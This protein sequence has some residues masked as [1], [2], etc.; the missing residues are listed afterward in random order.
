VSPRLERHLKSRLGRARTGV[1][2][3]DVDS[4]EPLNE[5]VDGRAALVEVGGIESRHLGALPDLA[6]LVR[7]RL[8]ALLIGVPGDADVHACR[9]E[10]DSRG[11]ADAGVG[12]GDDGTARIEGHG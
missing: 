3:E 8:S 1:V 7:C 5:V 11:S 4:T 2:H 10:C 12:G 6:D 9:R